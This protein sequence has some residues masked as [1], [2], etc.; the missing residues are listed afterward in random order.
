MWRHPPALAGEAVERLAIAADASLLL[1]IARGKGGMVTVR[2]YAAASGA[3][4]WETPLCMAGGGPNGS[5][6]GR[7]FPSAAASAAAAAFPHLAANAMPGYGAVFVRL[8]PP[9]GRIQSGRSGGDGGDATAAAGPTWAVATLGC[10]GAVALVRAADGRRLA[11]PAVVGPAATAVGIV[12]AATGGGGVSPAV[13]PQDVA[14][15]AAAGSGE[16]GDAGGAADADADDGLGGD[17]DGDSVFVLAL[18]EASG[19]LQSLA[20]RLVLAGGGGSGG[21]AAAAAPAASAATHT[22]GSPADGPVGLIPLSWLVAPPAVPSPPLPPSP[23]S[24]GASPV[25]LPGLP[26]SG[27][28]AVGPSLALAPALT[29]DAVWLGAATGG[30]PDGG[31]NAGDPPAGVSPAVAHAGAGR[32]LLA[33]PSGVAVV[34]ARTGR[35]VRLPLPRG[36]VSGDDAGGGAAAGQPSP[37]VAAFGDAAPG[38]VAL[39]GAGVGAVAAGAGGWGASAHGLAVAAFPGGGGGVRRRPW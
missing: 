19:A 6:S 30:A 8:T 16:G 25:P 28:A 21:A 5:P 24:R 38:A 36:G 31:G 12:S 29:W 10:G 37:L 11:A 13:P 34:D 15:V 32:F 17:V 3:L 39:L 35:A 20:L 2:V 18:D 27:K 4:A 7:S 14:A 23:P 22:R 9:I 26:V 33:G 1:S